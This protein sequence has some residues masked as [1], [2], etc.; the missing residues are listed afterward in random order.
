MTHTPM[1]NGIV[2]MLVLSIAL[3]NAACTMAQGLK[4]GDAKVS[5]ELCDTWVRQLANRSKCPFSEPYTLEPPQNVDRKGLEVVKVAYE[6]LASHFEIALP[7]LISGLRDRRYSYYQEVPTNGAFVCHDIGDACYD[8]ISRRIE[9]YRGSLEELDETGVPRSPDFIDAQGGVEKW[10]ASRIGRL[11]LD[12]QLEAIDW[13]LKQPKDKR[14]SDDVDWA[15]N[16]AA[17]RSFRERLVKGRRPHEPRIT[18]QFE[19]K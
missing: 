4:K 8:L 15:K 3:R 9:V 10:Y 16:L 12:L 19:G 14:I 1:V 13:A 11:L 7:S 2:A 18:L 17:L 6:K 5:R